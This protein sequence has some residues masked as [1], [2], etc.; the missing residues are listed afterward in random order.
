VDLPILNGAGDIGWCSDELTLCDGYDHVRSDLTDL[1]FVSPLFH[2]RLRAWLDY[3]AQRGIAV[4]VAPPSGSDVS[5]YMSRMHLCDELSELVQFPLPS[6]RENPLRDRLIAVTRLDAGGAV[7]F[8]DLLGGLLQSPDMVHA[9]H[10]AEV[11]DAAAQE[12]VLNAVDH[13]ANPVGAYVA[14]QRFRRPRDAAPHICI[15]AIGDMGIGMAAHLAHAGQGRDTDARTICHGMTEMV[16]SA[17]GAWHGRGYTVP[18]DVARQKGAAWTNVRVRAND[19]WAEKRNDN[20]PTPL[21][22]SGRP[23]VGTWVE[24]QFGHVSSPD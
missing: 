17:P 6:V 8:D 14:A 24:F 21:M 10:L 11:V 18:L 7:E 13:G 22:S 1:R 3:H 16:S 15:V 20:D 4:E 2:V 5:N 12:M 19:G 23:V 9:G